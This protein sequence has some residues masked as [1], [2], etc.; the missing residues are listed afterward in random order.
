MIDATVHDA[1]VAAGAYPSPL[2]YRGYAGDECTHL[3]A[4]RVWS[5][6][7]CASDSPGPCARP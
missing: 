4:H 7:K 3:I 6:H 1:I 2:G 5:A